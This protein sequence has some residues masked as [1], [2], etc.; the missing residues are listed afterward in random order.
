MKKALNSA[1]FLKLKSWKIISK[2]IEK[3]KILFAELTN[4]KLKKY[5]KKMSKKLNNLN[6]ILTKK[7][8]WNWSSPIDGERIFITIGTHI[9]QTLRIR[10][11]IFLKFCMQKLSCRKLEK[12][13]W[14]SSFFLRKNIEKLS[15]FI[16]EKAWKHLSYLQNYTEITTADYIVFAKCGV[17]FKVELLHFFCRSCFPIP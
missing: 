12:T 9:W 17:N 7:N 4:V 2:I 1:L 15:D 10:F 16:W 8:Y 5:W 11:Y 3:R 13:N 6:K 14:K